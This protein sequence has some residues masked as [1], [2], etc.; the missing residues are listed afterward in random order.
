MKTGTNFLQQLS[1][2]EIKEL[3]T[4]VKETLAPN[5]RNFSAA[6]LWHIQRQ[7]RVFRTR[8]HA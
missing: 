8:R 2:T 7:R 6:D 5:T 1:K 3:T 4:Q